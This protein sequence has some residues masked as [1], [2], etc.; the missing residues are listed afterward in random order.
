MLGRRG[1]GREEIAAVLARL[2]AARYLD[3]ADFARTWVT[4]RAHRG[5][6]GPARLVR[7]LRGK[8]IADAEI[9]AA[10]RALHEEWNAAEAAGEAARRKLKSLQGLSADA[11]RR[12]LAGYLD[13]RGF[14]P[15]IILVTCR[16]YLSDG[17]EPE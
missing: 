1:Y 11:A 14:A 8:G 10:L 2:S 9:E 3:D 16:K 4:T 6:A 12:R 7:E 17:P 5:T 15:D 13:R